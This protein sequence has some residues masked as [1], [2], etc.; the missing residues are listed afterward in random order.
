MAEILHQPHATDRGRAEADGHRRGRAH[1]DLHG[2][3]PSSPEA[4]P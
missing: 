1:A 2:H 3:T 4:A